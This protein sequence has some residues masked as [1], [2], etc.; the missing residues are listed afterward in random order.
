MISLITKGPSKTLLLVVTALLLTLSVISHADVVKF[1]Y[2]YSGS[3]TL[4]Q[5]VNAA[6]I[7]PDPN[8]G[9]TPATVCHGVSVNADG[10][11]L[12][13]LGTTQHSSDSNLA[14]ISNHYK[15]LP[16][17]SA[18][19]QDQF[20][21]LKS[22]RRLEHVA[23]GATTD[24]VEIGL[25]SEAVV[26][27]VEDLYGVPAS[28]DGLIIPQLASRLATVDADWANSAL[29]T[30]RNAFTDDE[31]RELH[32][33]N[34]RQLSDT[35]SEVLAE[36]AIAAMRNEGD[37]QGRLLV[38]KSLLQAV[39]DPTQ[40][41]QLTQRTLRLLN[42]V[43]GAEAAEPL[44][45]LQASRYSV[46]TG[47]QVVLDTAASLNADRFFGYD[48]LGVDS[49]KATAQFTR[50][51]TGSYLVC[52]TGEYI[53]GDE[54]STD[55]I[56]I[57]VRK[58]TIAI[59]KS[60]TDQVEVG[61]TINL[62]GSSSISADTFA[63]SGTGTFATPSISISTWTAPLTPGEH[64]LTLTINESETDQITIHVFEV[65]PIA[66]PRADQQV[67]LLVDGAGVQLTSESIT[68]DGSAVESVAW[69]II[70]RPVGSNPSITGSNLANARFQTDLPGDYLIRLTAT[71]H[72]NQDS[73]SLLIHA[74]KVGVP[75]ANAGGDRTAFRNQTLTLDGSASSSPD[76]LTLSYL[77]QSNT[78][79]LTN[80]DQ[81]IAK[82][83]ASE[84]GEHEVILTVTA[85]GEQSQQ[86]IK[87]TVVNQLPS[88]TDH[89]FEATIGTILHEQLLTNDPDG[90]ALEYQLISKPTL[91]SLNLDPITGQF[92]YL[93]GGEAGCLYSNSMLE[94]SSDQQV[95]VLRLCADRTFAA[96]GE[97][98]TLTAAPSANSTKL[99]ALT[100]IGVSSNSDTAQFSSTEVGIHLICVEGQMGS[101]HVISTA[102][103]EIE[104]GTG[105]PPG[106]DPGETYTDR[107]TYRVFDGYGHSRVA[108][109][110]ITI[111]WRNGLPV[112][113]DATYLL[114]PSATLNEQIVGSDIDGQ[115]LTFRIIDPPTLGSVTL[116]NAS[117]G[118]FRY[119]AGSV[120]GVDQFTV[121]ANDGLVDSKLATIKLTISTP[122]AGNQAPIALD[123]VNLT[124][125]EDTALT[126]QLNASDADGDALEFL[127]ATQPTR[128]SVVITNPTN[129][130]FLYT[131]NQGETGSDSFTFYAF[132]GQEASNH[133]TVSITI[134]ANPTPVVVNNA[135]VANSQG[136]LTTA[137]GV[138]INGTL[139][140]TD[141]DNDTLTYSI[142]TY[143]SRGSVE[144]NASTGQFSY[145]PDSSAV[146]D[147]LFTFTASD[148]ST[149][150]IPAQVTIIIEAN[151]N[152]PP[153]AESQG[154]LAGQ[155]EEN[156][157]GT[158]QGS[159]PEGA[160]LTF[161]ITTQS[162]NGVVTLIDAQAGTFRY[163]P[164][165][166]T[167][168]SD[169][170]SFVVNDGSRDS[171]PAE[172]TLDISNVNDLPLL[173]ALS[174]KSI[175]AD[176]TL[177]GQ[178]T[179]TDADNDLLT[180]R[181]VTNG[182]L[183]T[184]TFTNA[185]TGAFAYQPSGSVG[186]DQVTVDVTDSTAS[187]TPV[188]LTIDVLIAN[189]A[190]VAANL[191]FSAY[192]TVTYTGAFPSS[193]P[194]GNA[195]TVE[196]I[197]TPEW[198]ELTLIDQGAEGFSYRALSGSTGQD[199]FS[200]RVTDGLLW[201]ATAQV[202]IEISSA[203]DLC[204]GPGIGKQD[205]DDD[206]FAGF[207]ET[208]FSTNPDL[209][210]ETP[211]GLDPVALGVNFSNDDDGDGYLDYAELWMG[212]DYTDANSRPGDSLTAELPD[213]LTALYDDRAP[214]LMALAL[215]TA[216]LTVGDTGLQVSGAWTGLDNA[217]G[218][219]TLQIEMSSPSGLTYTQNHQFSDN[220]LHVADP[221]LL[222]E[223]G[224]YDEAGIWT[225]KQLTLTDAWGN[226]L[227]LSTSAL[228]NAGYA[229]QFELIN[230]NADDLPP[231]LVSLDISTPAVD[232]ESVDPKVRL[233]L[234]S[235]DN[236]S[237]VALA[238]FALRGPSGQFIYGQLPISP[239]NTDFTGEL[240]SQ[241][242]PSYTE[243]GT[244]TLMDLMLQD[245]A[246][247]TLQLSESALLARGIATEIT[248]TG[249]TPDL[250]APELLALYTTTS[251]IDLVGGPQTARFVMNT[252]DA[253]SGVSRVG[254]TLKGPSGQ[255]VSAEARSLDAPNIWQ[256]HL[257]TSEIGGEVETGIWQVDEATLED[258]AGNRV[259]FNAA[260]LASAEIVVQVEIVNTGNCI[261]APVN[262]LPIALG[263]SFT[264]VEEQ[265]VS[266]EMI[267]QD[268]DGD[269]LFYTITQP[270]SLG[271]VI[272][273]NP[274][275]GAFTYTPN[276][277][278]HGTDHFEFQVDVGIGVSNSATVVIEIS[279]VN[280][281]PI[282]ENLSL[283]IEQ[284]SQHLD[285]LPASDPDGDTLTY[286]ILSGPSQ[287]TFTLT[288]ETGAG[289]FQF[290]STADQ[291][292][293]EVVLYRV[294]DPSGE[295]ASGEIHIK[296]IP[297]PVL[298]E[299]TVL[300]PK[301]YAEDATATVSAE[302]VLTEAISLFSE[303]RITLSSPSDQPLVFIVND[304]DP[305]SDK[306]V[307]SLPV[308]GNLALPL[309]VGTWR[310]FNLTAKRHVE[311]IYQ[312]V[313][314]DIA[315]EGFNNIVTVVAGD[316][317][318]S[319]PPTA[320]GATL[321]AYAGVPLTGQLIG[322][323]PEDDPL[324]Y[325]ITQAPTKGSLD[326]DTA[327]GEFTYTPNSDALN[328]DSFWFR[329]D[330]EQF[331]SAA[332]A[333]NINIEDPSQ[334]CER[335]EPAPDLDNDGYI[336]VIEYA[337]ATLH[338]DANS[339]PVE[340]DPVALGIRFDDDD[341]S[342]GFADHIEVWLGSD[343]NDS[344]SRPTD[345]NDRKLPDCF[346][347]G[348]DAIRPR[349]LG[350]HLLTPAIIIGQD[351]PAIF[352]ALS[353]AD[354]AAGLKR[355]RVGLLT[356]SGVYTTFAA[357]FDDKPLIRGVQLRSAGLSDYSET[358]TWEVVSLTIYD[359]AGNVLRLDDQQLQQQGY[360]TTIMVSNP[361]SDGTPPTLSGVNILTDALDIDQ[362]ISTVE[363][364][365]DV[366]DTVAGMAIIQ[367]DLQSPSGQ[368]LALS[369]R[370]DTA[371][372]DARVR[373]TSDPMGDF[374]EAGVW[375]ISSLLLIDAAGN[376]VQL[377]DELLSRGLPN[378]LSVTNSQSDATPPSL[379]G[380]LVLNP[381][382]DPSSGF[383]EIAFAVT[384][385][386]AG[387]GIASIRIEV[388][389][390]SGQM[391]N[392]FGA[393]EASTPNSVDIQMQTTALNALT[394][395]G[396]WNIS[397]VEMVD[398]AGNRL[399]LDTDALDQLGVD[400]VIT[401][402]SN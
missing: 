393:F 375:Q 351:K 149:S 81:A 268:E 230:A 381:I 214:A 348:D 40:F 366:S 3:G 379:D 101:S 102:C 15:H 215:P 251:L 226:E 88:A 361:N 197:M 295:Q 395:R 58:P 311:G 400:R 13:D 153:L 328:S 335:G 200:Y 126:G 297:P 390:P 150:A 19:D 140:A 9:S 266:G 284:N 387:A 26:A 309:E 362:G 108:T 106:F 346:E 243:Q 129:G 288:P 212:T 122:D 125:T 93:A 376:S 338:N 310:L 283:T 33:R 21:L 281:A 294:E 213:C 257:A 41:K 340:L 397:R 74:D 236:L 155:E 235:T 154:P 326:V 285:H 244:W 221:V 280:N 133:A 350:Y 110:I 53:G 31:S 131:P 365:L 148:N 43:E 269:E 276:S 86:R 359:E 92:D 18:G 378:Q 209:A 70:E 45:V 181:V 247:N 306:V 57:K 28:A 399:L 210:A 353:L 186:T 207:I 317:P 271:R 189:R 216:P 286:S 364:E 389:G 2:A 56:Q 192:E 1:I 69:S 157:T 194:D 383:A 59:I 49:D 128:G 246:G 51:E 25:L 357:G 349:L 173:E 34:L 176:Q 169:Q 141:S 344:N 299:F 76:G 73:A 380:L 330:D 37:E 36:L 87:V 290:T 234:H 355:V 245:A 12:L 316:K 371:L 134:E 137:Q 82:F 352:L 60:D 229:T 183:G 227:T 222:L 301:L 32:N 62:D 4:L 205:R 156:L 170:F 237:G 258:A 356:P 123:L 161:R 360:P 89:Q 139:V 315:A 50:T 333:V 374:A 23:T 112:V 336:D 384:A 113:L 143:P 368:T 254:L 372:N 308:D 319:S 24:G 377:A 321:R 96:P 402:Q 255:H 287:G 14:L 388:T 20:I 259:V 264:T 84:L 165:A 341:D 178:F 11:F 211:V 272:I 91:G 267:A 231:V 83:I 63:W 337:F 327:T 118:N 95:P 228:T 325:V 347:V 252:S 171:T 261:C 386:D 146:G 175:P 324:T 304:I 85:G 103:V 343:P 104:I 320:E 298:R 72:G 77:W 202:T 98:V 188:T 130:S 151:P 296:V 358:G 80:A 182:S 242:V 289:G 204:R 401:L 263:S 193:D 190:P 398:G 174:D 278:A 318:A 370:F 107:F 142:I 29:A 265:P 218:I 248:F 369:H 38:R 391:L 239:A 334:A 206:G 312:V 238:T 144:L 313:A 187:A 22:Q 184:L 8:G 262:H 249:P 256:A 162:T 30:E 163:V 54:S 147:D 260:A 90:D 322:N 177:Q 233:A 201:S 329:V 160:D 7:C 115:T 100:W 363:I 274:T 27:A 179:A 225:L 198:G 17:Q 136:P 124:T 354:N 223:V 166:D 208:A 240:Q 35:D 94:V 167:F 111:G 61:N 145:Q 385:S 44:L 185:N 250:T 232:L 105:A 78:T 164:E 55:C 127:L 172:V 392:A 159:D 253:A 279:A 66:I 300:T 332:V 203:N 65:K 121:V 277:F 48:W 71:Y 282:A 196:I 119:Q 16:P 314:L 168:G 99:T 291:V 323:D 217:A 339:T 114:E 180:F 292:G 5:P 64:Q 241:T 10:T 68:S 293:D 302:V 47:T 382:I 273:D 158:L 135:P 79:L 307:F 345:S 138:T 373:L 46:K 275:T 394:E 303:M 97:V 367:L 219:A 220:P 39:A 67:Y 116:T 120:V 152:L 6:N 117:N 52:T 396:I 305:S 270:A 342:D 195:L 331:Q 191:S 109:V 132:D 42:L 75:V 224:K 199:Q